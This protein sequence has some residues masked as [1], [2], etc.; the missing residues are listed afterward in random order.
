LLRRVARAS[1]VAGAVLCLSIS[2]SQVAMSAKG[3]GGGGGGGPTPVA[4]SEFRS[5]E[6]G[7]V[8]SSSNGSGTA[9]ISTAG[10]KS[11]TGFAIDMGGQFRA[12][13]YRVTGEKN[14]SV[15]I[16]LPSGNITVTNGSGQT[17]TLHS[18]TSDPSGTGVLDNKGKLTVLVGATLSVPANQNAGTYTGTFTISVVDPLNP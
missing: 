18:F 5:L 12:G 13:E 3:G 15:D 1:L 17:A 7:D 16:T 8:A 14:T 4:V 9:T 6:F 11:T 2:G 10:V